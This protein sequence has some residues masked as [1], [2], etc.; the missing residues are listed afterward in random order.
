M[1][2]LI[3]LA[4][5]AGSLALFG[6]AEAKPQGDLPALHPAKV[7]RGGSPVAGGL[8]QFRAEPA[9]PEAADLIVN[10]ELAKDGTFV[11][12]TIHAVSMKKAVGAPAGTYRVTHM[13]AITAEQQNVPPMEL[14]KPVTIA[15]GPNELTLE[16]PTGKK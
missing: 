9:R 13:P 6:C 4:I 3:A 11:L 10:A 14:P 12:Q 2:H 15:P 8:L 16:L 1:K 5:M 7:T